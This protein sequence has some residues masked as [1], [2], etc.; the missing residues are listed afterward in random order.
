MAEP[1]SAAALH[2]RAHAG[3]GARCS[4]MAKPPALRAACVTR[5]LQ[6]AAPDPRRSP[7]TRPRSWTFVDARLRAGSGGG[8]PR[9]TSSVSRRRGRRPRCERTLASSDWIAGAAARRRASIAGAGAASHAAAVDRPAARCPRRRTRRAGGAGRPGPGS[10]ADPGC[11]PDGTRAARRRHRA[12]RQRAALP[13]RV[14]RRPTGSPRRARSWAAS[15]RRSPRPSGCAH[16]V[17]CSSGAAALQLASPP[18]AS[19]PATR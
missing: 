13:E 9:S 1:G 7:A 11:R 8:S 16:A 3:P 5:R 6:A 12:R 18:P 4:S 10:R 19:A 14:P 15:R 17:A 2:R